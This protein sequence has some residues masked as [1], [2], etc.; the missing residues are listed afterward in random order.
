MALH[1]RPCPQ[2]NK[3]TRI[4][5]DNQGRGRTHQQSLA[6]VAAA[7]Q[8]AQGALKPLA[9]AIHITQKSCPHE[10]PKM[11]I[12]FIHITLCA[13]PGCAEELQRV[14]V[15]QQVCTN[16]ARTGYCPRPMNDPK[17]RRGP[18]Y[19]EVHAARRLAEGAQGQNSTQSQGR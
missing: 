13:Q 11:C 19:C 5:H 14:P 9:E 16:Y 6:S 1:S 3:S 15:R 10:K 18:G 8:L 17:T 7:Y 4:E 12:I 2:K